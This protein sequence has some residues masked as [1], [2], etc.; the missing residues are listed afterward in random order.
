[1]T[2]VKRAVTIDEDVDR[3]ARELAGPS[4]S[5]FVNEALKRQ[6]RAAR[7]ERLV[8]RD[9][10]ERGPLDD[11]EVDAVEQQLAELDRT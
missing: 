9:A 3:A 2:T 10:E 11:R 6:V 8:D 1:M 7:L 5:A 4:F